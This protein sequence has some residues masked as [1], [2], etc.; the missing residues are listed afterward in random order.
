MLEATNGTVP[1][2]RVGALSGRGTG[3]EVV[4]RGV[5]GKVKVVGGFVVLPA[6]VRAGT[7]CWRPARLTQQFVVAKQKMKKSSSIS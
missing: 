2:Q 6:A 5:E 4:Q 3:W 1:V 7:A